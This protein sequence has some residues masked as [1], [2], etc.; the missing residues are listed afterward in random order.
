MD[1]GVAMKIAAYNVENLFDRAKVFNEDLE[2]STPILKAESRINQI[3][4]KDIYTAADKKEILGHLE[5]LGLLRTDEGE[6]AWL[7]RNRGALL[8]R[9]RKKKGEKAKPVTV[10]ANGRQ[11]WIGWVEL[12]TAPVDEVAVLNTGRVIRDVNADVL[13]VVEAENRT[14]LK[15]FSDALLEQVNGRPY[16]QIMLID[17]NDDRGIDVGLMTK[18]GYDIGLMRSHVQELR[19]NG[20]PVFAR[21]CPEYAVTTPNNETIWFLPNH[22]SSKFGGNDPSKIARR[23][24][25][26]AKVAEI[27]R[28]LRKEKQNKVVVLGDFNDT[29]DSAPL[30]SLLAETDLKDVSLHPKFDTGPFKGKGTFGNGSD[31]N[32]IDY[33][34]LSPA[35]FKRVTA[36]GLF[37][38]GA[39]PGKQ[40]PKWPVYP[41]VKEERDVASDHHV[42]WVEIRDP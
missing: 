40:N 13:A 2:T 22:F 19:A 3:F 20:E 1:K 10:V 37:R 35:L 34:L 31:K 38:M 17:G 29:P 16:D 14:A 18:L 21:D 11:D 12:K 4:E 24:D 25:Q 30:Q 15:Q 26:A 23:A 9:P 8:N 41:E 36:C 39:W 27:Y 5:T 42:I 33:L 6:F 28:R 7:R 32:K